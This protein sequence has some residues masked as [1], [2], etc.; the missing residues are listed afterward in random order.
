LVSRIDELDLVG[1]LG[2]GELL[3]RAVEAR[4]VTRRHSQRVGNQGHHVVDFADDARADLVD[5]VSGLDVGKIGFVDL[6]EIGLGQSAVARQRLVDDLVE[7]GVVSGRVDV[8]DFIVAGDSGLPE[9][10]DLAKRDFGEGHRAFMFVEHLDHPPR[11]QTGVLPAI[12]AAI[13][14]IIAPS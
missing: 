10:L 3:R 9:G 12:T 13:T 5:A 2:D 11:P 4:L 14:K 1:F 6:F 7:R 8:P